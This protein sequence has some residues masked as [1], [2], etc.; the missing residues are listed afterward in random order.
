MNP[1]PLVNKN[2]RVTKKRKFISKLPEKKRNFR[3]SI[4][5]EDINCCRIKLKKM[6]LKIAYEVGKESLTD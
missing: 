1:S 5:G 2:Q 6:T 4:L 3:L